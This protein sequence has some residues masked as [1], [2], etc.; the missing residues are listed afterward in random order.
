MRHVRRISWLGYPMS[1]MTVTGPLHYCRCGH[2][3]NNHREWLHECPQC[4]CVAYKRDRQRRH[5]APC[6]PSPAEPA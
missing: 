5:E 4:D 1:T 6:R 2:A 3:E